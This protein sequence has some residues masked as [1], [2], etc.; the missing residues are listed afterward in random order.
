M[1]KIPP[2]LLKE[3]LADPYYK[4]CVRLS[5]GGCQGRITLE[6]AIIFASKQLNEKWAILPLCTFHHA[7][8]EFQDSGDLQK[9]KNVHIALQRATNDEL[10]AVSKAINYF[11]LREVLNKKYGKGNK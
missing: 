6:H 5:D 3:I 1:R 4:V 2:K 10:K 8:D 9:E 11:R 7:V